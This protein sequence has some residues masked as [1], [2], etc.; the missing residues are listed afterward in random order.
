MGPSRKTSS[1]RSRPYRLRTT[2]SSYR[3]P[4][5]WQ[6][7]CDYLE[8]LPAA[9]RQWMLLFLEAE[10]GGNG[11]LLYDQAEQRRLWVRQK[12]QQHDAMTYSTAYDDERM[13]AWASMSPE[14]ALIDAHDLISAARARPVKR[15]ARKRRRK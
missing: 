8:A 10:Y 1:R 4:I 7:D 3:R 2:A 14:S 6:V 5:Q 11:H 15:D 13:T 12:H 9:E